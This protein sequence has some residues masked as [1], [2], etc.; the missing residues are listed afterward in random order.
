MQSSNNDLSYAVEK[1]CWEGDCVLVLNHSNDRFEAR[2][3]VDDDN[4]TIKLAK[5][6]YSISL[7]YKQIVLQCVNENETGVYMQYSKEICLPSCYNMTEGSSDS[8]SEDMES[9]TF[10]EVELLLANS[11]ACHKVYNL[12]CDFQQLHPDTD[13][14]GEDEPV[15]MDQEVTMLSRDMMAIDGQF[16]D[17]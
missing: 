13:S 9:D 4:I 10:T 11:E 6:G 16:E 7:E 5:D 17:A 1:N 14:E 12:M 2:A 15:C 3:T 8:D